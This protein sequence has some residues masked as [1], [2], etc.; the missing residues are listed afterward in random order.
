MSDSV[1]GTDGMR[2]EAIAILQ[3]AVRRLVEEEDGEDLTWLPEDFGEVIADYG[4]G[5]PI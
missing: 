2:M 1:P 4:L 3:A 5:A